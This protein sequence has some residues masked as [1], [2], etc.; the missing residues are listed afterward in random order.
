M[1]SLQKSLEQTSVL[2]CVGSGRCP[3]MVMEHGFVG[4][5]VTQRARVIIRCAAGGDNSVSLASVVLVDWI[6]SAPHQYVLTLSPV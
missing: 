4:R 5:Y 6:V 3:C 1:E 2:L